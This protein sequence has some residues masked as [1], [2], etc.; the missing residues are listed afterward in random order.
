MTLLREVIDIPERVTQSDFVVSLAEGVA[1]KS[2]TLRQYVVT[3]Q[4]QRCFDRA[5]GLVAEGVTSGRS[6]ATFLHGSFGSGKS[7]FMAVLYQL[8]Q[9]DADARAMPDLQPVYEKYDSVLQGTKVLGLT[10][11]FQDPPSMEA[12]ILGGYVGQIRALHPGCELPAVHQTDALLDNA[13][14]LRDTFG[15]EQFFARLNAGKAG[16]GAVSHGPRQAR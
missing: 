3:P 9:R 2:D 13:D 6:Q 10:Y 4:L 7:H 15:D 1:N 14:Q 12:Q 5:L 11:R 8:L 16:S